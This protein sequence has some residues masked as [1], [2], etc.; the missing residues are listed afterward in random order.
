MSKDAEGDE[1]S[2]DIQTIVENFLVLFKSINTINHWLT[3]L[4]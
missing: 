4:L 1:P 3:Y 2:I